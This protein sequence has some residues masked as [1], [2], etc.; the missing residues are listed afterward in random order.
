[1]VVESDYIDQGYLDDFA[2]YYIHCFSH[3]KKRCTRV[4]FF[5]KSFTTQYFGDLL[6]GIFP[7]GSSLERELQKLRKAYRGFM[8]IKPLPETVI[9]R[10]CLKTYPDLPKRHY[11]GITTYKANLFGIELEVE[12]LP[13]QE[14]DSVVA[15][16]ATSALWSVL[17]ATSR[18]LGHRIL[19]PAAIT[20]IAYQARPDSD[21]QFP[22]R[23]LDKDQM[24]CA[25]RTLGLEVDVVTAIGTDS[26]WFKAV[27]YAY[28]R[29]GLPILFVFT[30][31]DVLS[32]EETEIDELHAVAVA[33]Y[34]RAGA[35]VPTSNHRFRLRAEA[36]DRIYAHDD[37]LG[38]FAKMLIDGKQVKIIAEGDDSTPLIAQGDE[39][40]SL[41]TSWVSER[42]GASNLRAI[43][44]C[45]L[46]PLP[47]LVKLKFGCIYDVVHSFSGALSGAWCR[48]LT[49]GEEI[50]WSIYLTSTN[51]L[52]K[53]LL[54]EAKK[55]G[56]QGTELQKAL[57]KGF[58]KYVWRAKALNGEMSWL[59]LFFD[60]TAIEQDSYM[61]HAIKYDKMF[62]Q[63]TIIAL[64]E[65]H[66]QQTLRGKDG[67][68]VLEWFLREKL[69]SKE[70]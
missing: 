9:G 19:S 51:E 18:K 5:S 26:S 48:H 13:F 16:C 11:R 22:S 27:L 34:S 23:G 17:H 14:Q 55:S 65:K 1:M 63:V 3:Y 43:P 66:T 10:T 39:F 7:T 12:S 21:G 20:K 57:T 45:L 44:E 60:A 33:G 49:L 4:H 35:T 15:A 41:S 58:P 50:E 68:K 37:G 31:I 64:E 67:A 56:L 38:P 59:D 25:M 36:I 40:F 53:E 62:W 42:D 54:V 28:L 69:I 29:N 70:C 52:K 6:Q 24:S 46:V 61:I 32:D 47:A 30:L 2:E 8:V